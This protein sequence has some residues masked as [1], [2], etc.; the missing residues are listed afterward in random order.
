MVA[1]AFTNYDIFTET[2]I[3]SS[4][5]P[6]LDIICETVLF[7]N[8]VGKKPATLLKVYYFMNICQGILQGLNYIVLA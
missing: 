6:N 1:S 5:R 2:A 3:K 7:L 8:K 4:V